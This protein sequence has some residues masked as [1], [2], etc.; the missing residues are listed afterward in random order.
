MPQDVAAPTTSKK[1]QDLLP[2]G[3][4]SAEFAN[5]G[6]FRKAE[7]TVG[8]TKLAIVG[9]GSNGIMDIIDA[10]VPK[11]QAL[12]PIEVEHFLKPIQFRWADEEFEDVERLKSVLQLTPN[13]IE[14]EKNGAFVK[15]I[16]EY[17]P[18]P[19][20]QASLTPAQVEEI[21]K[22]LEFSWADE[23]FDDD[24]VVTPFPSPEL[25]KLRY[26]VEDGKCV[27]PE[28]H[29]NEGRMNADDMTPATIPK[30]QTLTAAEVEEL[31]KPIDFS[32]ADEDFDNNP[33]TTPV[34]TKGATKPRGCNSG[35]AWCPTR[36][37]LHK[38][39]LL[40][41]DGFTLH[42]QMADTELG[43]P[44]YVGPQRLLCLYHPRKFQQQKLFGSK[45]EE[46]GDGADCLQYLL[47]V[48]KQGE[49]LGVGMSNR[50]R[51]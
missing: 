15:G 4:D 33:V 47:W 2:V 22:P 50:W 25:K 41:D 38:S 51:E 48:Q 32:W 26:T 35:T 7:V 21:L 20:K 3:R 18:V 17:A 16:V 40:A 31:L 39:G 46:I 1:D 11:K 49:A 29:C 8:E 13:T 34:F 5:C 23:E 30:S 19:D 45:V 42:S 6:V 14:F 9:D 24:P 43:G 36:Q 10:T 12:T 27:N 28:V 44:L 37:Q